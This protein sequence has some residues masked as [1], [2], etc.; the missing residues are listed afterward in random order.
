MIPNGTCINGKGLT[1]DEEV[2]NVSLSK[3]Q[4]NGHPIRTLEDKL[5]SKGKDLIAFIIR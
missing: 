1:P 4:T 2:D 3:L 5:T